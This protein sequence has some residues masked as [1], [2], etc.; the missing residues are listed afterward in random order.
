LCLAYHFCVARG[1][2]GFF[3]WVYDARILGPAK[4]GKTILV[5]SDLFLKKLAGRYDN[6]GNAFGNQRQVQGCLATAGVG[7]DGNLL[8][9]GAYLIVDFILPTIHLLEWKRWNGID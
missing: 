7:C 4:Q 3:G 5:G 9:C 6:R 8:E 1:I 2:A